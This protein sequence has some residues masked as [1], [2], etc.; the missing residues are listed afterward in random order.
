MKKK[1]RKAH[2]AIRDCPKTNLI[3]LKSKVKKS[4]FHKRRIHLL[5]FLA[6]VKTKISSLGAKKAEASNRVKYK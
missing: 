3:Y 2:G 4:R 5:K 6:R 1:V